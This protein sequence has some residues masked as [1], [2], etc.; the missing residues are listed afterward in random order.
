MAEAKGRDNWAHTSTV[1]A[2][3]ANVNR[4]PR[5]TRAFK[6]KDFNPFEAR[7]ARGGVPL[8]VQ[9]LGMLKQVFVDQKGR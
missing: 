7:R 1:L 4:D 8:T 5:R 6:P 3:L 9:N 2:L